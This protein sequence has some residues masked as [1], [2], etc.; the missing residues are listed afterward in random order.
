[1]MWWI[2]ALGALLGSLPDTLDWLLAVLGFVPRWEVYSWF[3]HS[4]PTWAEIVVF[5][6]GLHV[7]SDR[8]VHLYPGYAWWPDFWYMEIGMW[9]VSGIVLSIAWRKK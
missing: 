5:P 9:I 1:V 7:W 4:I 3:H 6:V 8:L 2:S